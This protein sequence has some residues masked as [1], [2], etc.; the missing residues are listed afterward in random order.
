ME[1]GAVLGPLGIRKDALFLLGRVTE[2]IS[3][4]MEKFADERLNI[5]RRLR[6]EAEFERL[7]LYSESLRKELDP[8]QQIAAKVQATMAQF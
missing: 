3:P 4:D 5:A 2:K 1:Q 8:N 6:G 7:N